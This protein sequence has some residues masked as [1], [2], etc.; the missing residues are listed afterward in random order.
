MNIKKLLAFINEKYNYKVNYL[1]YSHS[2]SNL[3]IYSYN[4]GLTCQLM[5]SLNE[6]NVLICF[7]EVSSPNALDAT[8]FSLCNPITQ[9][10]TIPIVYQ[11]NDQSGYFKS[12]TTYD[13]TIHK[14]F[15]MKNALF[16]I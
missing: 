14:I 6:E 4:K 8:S 16:L 13:K 5:S 1:Q 10:N 11:Q 12:A 3:A 7:Y 2:D 15:S 9:S